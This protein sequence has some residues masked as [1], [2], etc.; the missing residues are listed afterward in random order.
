VAALENEKKVTWD[1]AVLVVRR[2]D[3]RVLGVTRG[4]NLRDINLPGGLREPE[5]PSPVATARREA[6]EET[7][8]V[9]RS[10]RPLAAWNAR[11]RRVIA[12][13]GL[14]WSGRLQSSPEGHAAWA[15]PQALTRAV[16]TFQR[17]N[18]RL[19]KL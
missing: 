4:A 2:P 17:E 6:R 8:L 18:D 16:C 12:F 11:G 15:S 10:L 7:G 5:D 14:N 3:G 1:A 19:L 13:Q 9:V